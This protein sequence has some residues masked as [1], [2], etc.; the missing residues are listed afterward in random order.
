MIGIVVN[1]QNIVLKSQPITFCIAIK[2][3]PPDVSPVSADHRLVLLTSAYLQ[4]GLVSVGSV[5][6]T[7]GLDICQRSDIETS[8]TVFHTGSVVD[9]ADRL[10][11][12]DL[13][14]KEIAAQVLHQLPEDTPLDEPAFNVSQ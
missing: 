5:D 13:E 2:L 11:I 4:E 14:P 12:T 3:S 6:C 1:V 9:G 8:Q 7:T 10:V